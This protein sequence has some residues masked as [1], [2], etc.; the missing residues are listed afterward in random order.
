MRVAVVGASGYT[1]A[2]L[3][4]LLLRH[5]EVRITLLTAERHKG[6][7]PEEVFG[8]LRG[9]D[10]P[11]LVPFDPD[12]VAKAA[13]MAF[14]ALPHGASAR[15][16]KELLDRGLKVIDLSADF[17]LKD[18]AVYRTYYG[19]HPH[20]EL[21]REAVYGLPELYRER[22]KGARLVANPGC[23]PTSVILG[24]YPLARRGLVEGRVFVDSKSGASG[25]G[26]AL[27]ERM[28]FCEVAE[29]IRPYNPL[30]HR[31][32]PEMEQELGIPISFVP[33]LLPIN[34]GILS[35]IYVALTEPMKE[36]DLYD[37]YLEDYKEE[38][39]VRVL[40]PGSL[41]STA[42]VRGSNFCDIGF[43]VRGDLAVI[44]S[45]IDNLTKGASGQA[46]QNMNL[47]AGFSETLGLESLP[48]FP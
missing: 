26:R 5:P 40:P 10:L 7:K 42:S 23:Y 27:E 41:P 9:F 2:E 6:Q 45:A 25:A 18:P 29:G 20:P 43:K 38:P 46:I 1:G 12:M 48:L 17:R 15:A 16:A 28:L 11:G 3:L 13:D 35:T 37:L 44:C 22:V 14:L 33:H 47:M 36:A 8:S 34:R 30:S 32:V 19:N 4:R 21:L 31:H 39:F 24:L